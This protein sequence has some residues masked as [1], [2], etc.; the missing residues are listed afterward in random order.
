[1][2]DGNGFYSAIRLDKYDELG[3][4]SLQCDLG[5]DEPDPPTRADRGYIA[6]IDRRTLERECLAHGL[7]YHHIDRRVFTF[8]SLGEWQQAKADLGIPSAVLFNAGNCAASDQ[9]LAAE[10]A[11][12]VAAVAPAA[13]VV[14][15][16]NQEINT[17]LD[18]I[19]LGVRGYV[20]SSVSIDVCIQAIS[21]AIA[22]G[23]FIPASSVLNIRELLGVPSRRAMPAMKFTSRQSAIAQ[24]LRCGKANKD[25]ASELN[26]CE[27]TIK[28]HIRNIMKKLGATNRTEVACKIGD[29]VCER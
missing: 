16:D 25:I 18:I 27:S 11:E 3:A 12:L 13:V 15:S 24:A 4:A 20:P 2:I 17:V 9:Q 22:G 8:S 6:L 7:D 21:L 26:L 10:I 28:V 14:L 29:M 23:R 1:M 19:G 5:N